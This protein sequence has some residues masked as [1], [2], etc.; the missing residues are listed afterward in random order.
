MGDWEKVLNIEAPAL[1]EG[2]VWERVGGDPISLL[3][4][5]VGRNRLGDIFQEYAGVAERWNLPIV[6]F[7]PTWRANQERSKASANK[8]AVDFV[9][10]FSRSTG[11]LMGPRHDCYQPAAALSREEARVFHRWQANELS[12][13]EFVLVSTMPSV[14]EALGIVDVVTV[15]CVVSFVITARGQLLDGTPLQDAISQIDDSANNK[16]IGYWI[17]CV[18]PKTVSDGLAAVGGQAVLHRLLGVQGNTSIL[19]PRS[20]SATSDFKGESPA[21]FGEAMTDLYR[22]FSVPIL[23]GCCGTRAEHLEEIA[24]HL[25]ECAR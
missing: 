14:S 17:N 13:A 19:D 2:S 25:V 10:Q 12:D 4:T 11:A 15:P 9:R 1:A 3:D 16:P 8:S 22:R 24:R 6:L 21:S 18:H 20:F 23:G 5:A 7:A